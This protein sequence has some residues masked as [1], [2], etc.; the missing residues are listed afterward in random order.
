[1]QHNSHIVHTTQLNKSR[2][3]RFPSILYEQFL[4]YIPNSK[5]N[6]KKQN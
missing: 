2:S 6:K 4:I 5:E 1:M 3:Y